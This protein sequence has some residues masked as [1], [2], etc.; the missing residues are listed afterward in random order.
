MCL[1]S[2]ELSLSRGD[3]PAAWDKASAEQ[4]ASSVGQGA[5]VKYCHMLVQKR[6]SSQHN[7]K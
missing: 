6:A 7:Q 5:S 2:E 3:E 4:R 1:S